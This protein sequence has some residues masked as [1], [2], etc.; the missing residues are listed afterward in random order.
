MKV[1]II[2]DKE[3]EIDVI[4]LVNSEAD[5]NCIQEGLIPTK[6]FQKLTEQLN[7]TNESQMTIRY[8][9]NIAHVC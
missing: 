2:I 9:V 8:E 7:P 5:L 1:K 6:Y 4:V 3:Q